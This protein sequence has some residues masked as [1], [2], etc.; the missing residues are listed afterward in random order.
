MLEYLSKYAQKAYR[1]ISAIIQN[2]GFLFS[3]DPALS[4][5]EASYNY[6]YIHGFNR[7]IKNKRISKEKLLDA[8]LFIE[9]N[10]ENY[11]KNH[12]TNKKFIFYLNA[13]TLVPA[14]TI[15]VVSFY[16]D[17][18]IM[19]SMNLEELIDWYEENAYFDGLRILESFEEESEEQIETEYPSSTRSYVKLIET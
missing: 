14:F 18:E 1:E 11:L 17:R 15:T 12:Y 9:N 4:K 6:C 10:I 2:P 19:E 3:N 13:D 5:R 7:L 8:L 16:K